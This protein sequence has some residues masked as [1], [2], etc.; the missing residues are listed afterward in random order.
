MRR[1]AEKSHEP[2]A[3]VRD[4]VLANGCILCG[5]AIGL[6]VTGDVARTCCVSC[7]WISSPLMQR[8]EDGEVHVVHPAAGLA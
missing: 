4:V 7:R 5:G 3:P 1:E 8:G 2:T 6:R